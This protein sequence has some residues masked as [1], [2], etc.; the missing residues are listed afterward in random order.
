MPLS[1]TLMDQELCNS[2]KNTERREYVR[3]KAVI[4]RTEHSWQGLGNTVH[5]FT[6]NQEDGSTSMAWVKLLVEGQLC[7]RGRCA[8]LLLAPLPAPLTTDC[9]QFSIPGRWRTWR[10]PHQPLLLT[11]PGQVNCDGSASTSR[12]KERKGQEGKS[13]AGLGSAVYNTQTVCSCLYSGSQHCGGVERVPSIPP[14]SQVVTPSGSHRN[15]PK[16]R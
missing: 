12:E 5:I 13:T 9:I 15:T 11:A 8:S 6:S 3:V 14:N 7:A 10:R 16:S 4:L 1:I 2:W